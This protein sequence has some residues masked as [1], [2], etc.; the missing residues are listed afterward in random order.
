[1]GTETERK[2]LVIS[3]EWRENAQGVTY[4]QAYLARDKERTVRVRV[5]GDEGF[6]TVKGK[7]LEDGLTKPEYEYPIPKKD[8]EELLEMCLPGLVE[9]TRYK[10]RH[11]DGHLWEVDVFEGDNEGLIVAEVE[12]SSAAEKFVKPAWVGKEITDDKRYTNASLS[13]KPYKTWQKRR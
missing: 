13:K 9:K 2:F 10:I 3:D 8:A 4:R 1:M 11:E 6:I 7:T 5:A 12:L